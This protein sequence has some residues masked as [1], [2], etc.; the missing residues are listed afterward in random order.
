M[1]RQGASTKM[2]AILY[3]DGCRGVAEKTASELLKAF[4]AHVGVV[5]VA[6][7]IDA[8]WPADPAWTK[9]KRNVLRTHTLDLGQRQYEWDS[10]GRQWKRLLGV[11]CVGHDVAS[12]LQQF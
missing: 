2:L 7:E 10:L 6:A 12:A 9:P 11:Q 8:P 1:N 3:Q 5:L 4:V